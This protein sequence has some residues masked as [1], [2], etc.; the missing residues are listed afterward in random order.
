LLEK[1]DLDRQIDLPMV[2]RKELEK[3]VQTIKKE[4]VR[5]KAALKEACQR[6]EKNHKPLHVEIELLLSEYN[7]SSAAYHGGELNGVDRWHFMHYAD[8]KNFEIQLILL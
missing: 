5:R 3:S 4:V 6:K 1:V 8:T 2:Q 7:I